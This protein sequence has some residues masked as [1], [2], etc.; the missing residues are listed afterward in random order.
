MKC[1][2][3]AF[4][5]VKPL[6]SYKPVFQKTEMLVLILIHD[7][8]GLCAAISFIVLV[9]AAAGDLGHDTK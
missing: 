5:M 7:R 8:W 2:N 9:T 6:Y 4:D 3:H 1:K